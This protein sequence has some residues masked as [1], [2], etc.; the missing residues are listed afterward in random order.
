MNIL[1]IGAGKL[2]LPLARA[3]HSQGHSVT[4]LSRQ[5]KSVPEGVAHICHDVHTLKASQL[6]GF[7]WVYVIL[8]PDERSTQGYQR[9]Y[10]DSIL[11]ILQ[12]V[13]DIKR[14]IYIS[15]TQVYGENAG[16]T[17]TD[18]TPPQP[19]SDYGRILRAAELLWHAHLGD[20]LTIIRPSGL[21]SGVSDFLSNAAKNLTHIEDHHWLN[22]IARED[23]VHILACLPEYA[24]N[25]PLADAYILSE[26]QVIRHTLLNTLRQA[27][28]LAVIDAPDTLPTTGKKLSPTRLPELLKAQNLTLIPAITL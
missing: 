2:G 4:T 5:E 20:K 21:M 28:G 6:A 8:T 16:E 14:L 1:I 11:P 10:V 3:L 23:V 9:A 12:A 18:N 17:V 22:L 27:Q 25:H 7:D 24:K 19:S 26:T 13:G 15:S